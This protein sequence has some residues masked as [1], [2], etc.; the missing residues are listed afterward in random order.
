LCGVGLSATSRCYLTIA[1]LAA[2]RQMLHE[3]IAGKGAT[4]LAFLQGISE[5]TLKSVIKAGEFDAQA[6]GLIYYLGTILGAIPADTPISLIEVL[7]K[8]LPP[9]FD[10]KLI[11]DDAYLI[12]ANNLGVPVQDIKPLSGQ[13]LGTGTQASFWK[14]RYGGMGHATV[15]PENG[16]TDRIRPHSAGYHRTVV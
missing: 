15:L 13:G 3:F 10:P 12:Y 5:Q 2:L 1:T 9:G 6:K 16:G 4:K 14:G 8:Q 11:I 7:L